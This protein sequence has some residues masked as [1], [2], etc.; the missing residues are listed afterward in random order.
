MKEFILKSL[1]YA[2]FGILIIPF[3]IITHELGHFFAYHLLGAGN[4]ELHAFSVSADKDALSS[5]EIAFANIVGPLIT[6]LMIALA[7]FYTRKNYHFVWIILALAA[8][9]GRIVNFVYIYF[10]LAGYHPNPNFDEFN[11]SK[12]IGIEPL[13][14]SVST[15]ILVSAVFVVFFRKAWFENRFSEIGAIILSIIIGVSVWSLIG[16]YILP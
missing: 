11:F 5:T 6:Y 14:L 1:K 7:Y 16:G 15:A 3:S 13:F 9:L 12:N 4:V 2:G 10:R 8:P